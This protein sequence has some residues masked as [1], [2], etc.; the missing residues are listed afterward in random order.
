[1]SYSVFPELFIVMVLGFVFFL[2]ASGSGKDK[3]KNGFKALCIFL[4]V[5]YLGVLV[6]MALLE[7]ADRDKRVLILTPLHSVLRILN[8]YNTFDVFKQILDNILVFIPFGML[9]PAAA[10]KMPCGKTF[11]LTSLCGLLASLGIETMQYAFSLGYSE[12]DDLIFNTLGTMIGA[13][14]YA[15]SG[16]A[17]YKNGSLNLKKGWLVYLSPEFMVSA[18]VFAAWIYR[19]YILY[20]K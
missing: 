3:N 4:L 19:E 2:M 13:G 6:W 1:M 15:M 8:S 12:F 11:W 14:V 10:G 18:A 20:R 16:K 17:E 5:V 9:L 7:R